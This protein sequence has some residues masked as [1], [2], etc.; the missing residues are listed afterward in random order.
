MFTSLDFLILVVMAL[1]AASLIAM[2]LMFLVRNH[3]FRQVSLYLV[4]ALGVYISCVGLSILWPNFMGQVFVAV[5]TLLTSLGAI[6]LE[7][8]R[9]GSGKH[10]L[11]A[12]ILASAALI[13]S[14]INAFAL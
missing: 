10:F 3:R 6:V 4:S 1:T 2:V 9:K 13:A 5:L 7:R 8:V 12:R 14:L 11:A